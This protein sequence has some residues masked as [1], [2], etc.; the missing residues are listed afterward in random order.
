[1]GK[2]SESICRFVREAEAKGQG[3]LFEYLCEGIGIKDGDTAKAVFI[4]NKFE[5]DLGNNPTAE[6]ANVLML[7]QAIIG[8]KQKHPDG[9]VYANNLQEM[10]GT[11]RSWRLCRTWRMKK[12]RLCTDSPRI[13]SS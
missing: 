8:F 12:H 6:E 4:R 1:M 2:V 13:L 3:A 9:S 7:L 10:P 11:R 5:E